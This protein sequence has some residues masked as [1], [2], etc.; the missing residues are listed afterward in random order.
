MVRGLEVVHVV[1]PRQG[2]LTI[3]HEHSHRPRA[4]RV[5]SIDEVRGDGVV[6]RATVTTKARVCATINIL[7]TALVMLAAL[8]WI[9]EVAVWLFRG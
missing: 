1:R 8:I 4:R 9:V 2:P 6:T 3:L 7:V 5:R